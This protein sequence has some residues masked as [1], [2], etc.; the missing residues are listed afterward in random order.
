MMEFTDRELEM[1]YV[2]MIC[3]ADNQ[4][5]INCNKFKKKEIQELK[6][7]VRKS[8]WDERQFGICLLNDKDFER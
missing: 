6:E 5:M 7:K 4:F 8:Y 3:L 2:G 1:L